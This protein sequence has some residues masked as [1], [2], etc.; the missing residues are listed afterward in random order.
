MHRLNT[1]KKETF[2]IS[3]YDKDKES[4]YLYEVE[5]ERILINGF[6]CFIFIEE[7]IQEGIYEG[8]VVEY[9]NISHLPTGMR[10]AS[11]LS[12]EEA[13]RK[14]TFNATK[15]QECIEKGIEKIKELN[16]GYPINI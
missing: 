4:P 16:L 5:G 12:K 8:E 2:K 13:I 7:D 9:Y 1:P 15:Y 14:A 10:M 11:N 6:E 3:S